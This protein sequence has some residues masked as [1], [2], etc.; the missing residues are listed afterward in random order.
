MECEVLPGIRLRTVE[1][2]RFK[3]A[4][5]AVAFL[6]PLKKETASLYAL[7]PFILR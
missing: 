1:T 4:S 5:F 2:H 6:S 3:T 7:L